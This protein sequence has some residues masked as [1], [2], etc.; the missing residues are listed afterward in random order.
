MTKPFKIESA[1]IKQLSDIQL[2]QLLKE[3]L[4][5]EAFKFE[6]SQNSIEVALNII[7]G[8][9]GEDGRISWDNGISKTD[10]IPNRLTLFQNKATEIGPAAYGK[11]LLTEKGDIKNQV[12]TVLSNNG[13]Y[14]VFT[15]QELNKK[16]KNARISS[17]RETLKNKN[18]KYHDTCELLIYD[19]SDIAGWVNCYITTVVAVQHWS[20]RP[21]ERGLKTFELWSQ[22]EDFSVLPFFDASSRTAIVESLRNELPNPKSCL[23]IMGLSGL[24]KTRTAFEVF[25]G[26]SSLQNLVV[27]VDANHAPQIDALVADWVSLGFRAILVIDNCE[28]RLH[29]RLVKEVRREK[30]H[31]SLLTLDYNFDSVSSPTISYKLQQMSDEELVDMLNPVYRNKLTDLQRVSDFAQGFPQ[32][33]VLLAEARLNENPK[34][35]ELSEDELANKLLWARDEH[36]NIDYLKTLQ[37]CSLF[38]AFGVEEDVEY[39]LEY[40]AQLTSLEIDKVYECIQRFTSRGLIDRRGRFGQVVPKPLAIR[41]AGQW[42]TNT[43]EK[44]QRE[45]IDG[46]PQGMVDRFC[47]Q[48][49]KLD[50]HTNVKL[51]T[52]ALCGPK[53]PFGQ[54]EVILS[55][56]GSRLFRAFVNVNSDDTTSALYNTLTNLTHSDLMSIQG[57]TRRNLV[58]ALEKLC[59]HSEV[60][61][62]AAWCLLL[63][64]ANENETWSNNATGTFTQLFRIDLSGTSAPP[65]SRFSVL[66]RALQKKSPTI[67]LVLIKSLEQAISLYGGHRTI[68][69]EYQGTKAPLQEWRPTIWQEVFDYWQES[70]DLLLILMTR[71]ASQKEAVLNAIGYSIRG[72]VSKGRIA[73]LDGAIHKII[74]INGKYWP[75]AAESIKNAYNFD[76]ESLNSEARAALDHW[77]DLLNPEDSDLPSKLKILVTNPPWEH[78]KNEHGGYD[79]IAAKKAENLAKNISTRTTELLPHVDLLLDGQQKQAYIF[80]RTLS[81]ESNSTIKLIEESLT[82]IATKQA[83]NLLFILGLFNGVFEKDPASWEH[84]I[85]TL[86]NN[87]NLKRYYPE[88]IRTG[89]IK[90]H[91]LQKLINLIRSRE[92]DG[93]TANTL[94][95]GSVTDNVCDKDISNFC[96]Q[97]SEIGSQEA[98][99]ALNIVFMH[100]FSNPDRK[101]NLRSTIKTLVTRVPLSK[102][103]KNLFKDMHHWQDLSNEILKVRDEQFAVEIANQLIFACKDGYDHNDIWT[104]T[105]PLLTEIMKKYGE[106]IWPIFSQA[107]LK[108]QGMELYWLQQLLDRENSVST[109]LPSVLSALPVKAVIDWCLAN[110]DTAP[111]FV[112][113]CIDVIENIEDGRQPSKLFISLLETFGDKN[114]VLNTLRANLASRGW[115]GSLVPYLEA[116]KQAIATLTTKKNNNVRRWAKNYISVLDQQI[117]NETLRD[118]EQDLGIF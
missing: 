19:A 70:I 47:L 87:K 73:M 40:I 109:Q 58:W 85:E 37:A 108:A 88:F 43:R 13:S 117:T 107:I 103:D 17:L 60:F 16:Q 57:D 105:K 113:S 54:A 39:Q 102:K 71:G 8:D 96:L 51:L 115:T 99:V 1:D 56:R 111:I 44:K 76:I 95:Y 61:E 53:G 30:S 92:I 59:F 112:A 64:A 63:L 22:H 97:L 89:E 104:Y 101:A 27:Y 55:E 24:G 45:L 49:E 94:S 41:L 65:S 74:K 10:Y 114:K 28:Y 25:A 106:V 42:W 68:G 75:S 23:R 14:V 48:I 72:F 116:D 31:I 36:E 83:P 33:A 69:A 9:G 50:F 34:L 6:L 12:D 100:C 81:I 5:S 11:E 2:T 79:D 18:K 82:R 38:D 90:Q 15:T 62:E 4:H 21:V 91:H 77:S 3:L 26:N 7:T 80:G 67:D 93:N 29:E 78:K 86:A 110:P 35:G 66:T 52:E 32:M 46:L 84:L 20:G 98:W 118:E